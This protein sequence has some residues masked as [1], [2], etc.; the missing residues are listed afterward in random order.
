MFPELSNLFS[1]PYLCNQYYESLI[2]SNKIK[3]LKCKGVITRIKAL[4]RE[5]KGVIFFKQPDIVGIV[6]KNKTEVPHG[7]NLKK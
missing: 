5:S 3:K 1:L 7:E 2:V 4:L 6:T